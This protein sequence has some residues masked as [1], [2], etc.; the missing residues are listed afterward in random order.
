MDEELKGL[1]VVELEER[2]N[3]VK[4]DGKPKRE[5]VGNVGDIIVQ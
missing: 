1:P 3:G 5:L 2:I 4:K